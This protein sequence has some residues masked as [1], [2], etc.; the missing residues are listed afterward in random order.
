MMHLVLQRA[1]SLA[2]RH[3]NAQVI[4]S[5]LGQF[6][7]SFACHLVLDKTRVRVSECNLNT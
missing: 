7:S 5:L 3:Q 4:D 1:S 2:T 6:G